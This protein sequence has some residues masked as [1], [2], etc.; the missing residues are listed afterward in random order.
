MALK[1]SL[2]STSTIRVIDLV[3]E[4]EIVGLVDGANSVF[5][6]EISSG[7]REGVTIEERVGLPSQVP[8]EGFPELETEVAVGTQIKF[9]SPYIGVVIDT[10]VDAL[11]IKVRVPA[12]FFINEAGVTK[13]TTLVVYADRRIVGEDWE[14]VFT[15]FIDG[16]SSGNY[17][18]S[19][20]MAKPAGSTG[21]WEFRISRGTK[22]SKDIKLQNDLYISTY[23]LLTEVKLEYPD[24]AVYG[25]TVDTG[26]FGTRIPTRSFEVKGRIIQVPANY[27]PE[28]RDQNN[29]FLWSEE[30]D[31][32]AWTKQ[33][34]AITA[35]AVIAPDGILSADTF[36]EDSST[37]SHRVLQAYSAH[38]DAT[39]YVFS[40]E[41][42]ASTRSWVRIQAGSTRYP[43]SSYVFFNSTDGSIGN[44]GAGIVDSSHYGVEMTAEGFYRFWVA[45]TTT[46][47][48][49]DGWS[50]FLET[51]N[52]VFSYTGDGSSGLHFWGAQI[53][54]IETIGEYR[55]TTD[56]VV[57]FTGVGRSYWGI[58]DGTFKQAWTDNPAWVMYDILTHPRYGLGGDIS[59]AQVDKWGLD[60]IGRYCDELI[61]D[62]EDGTEPRF[63]FNGVISTAKEAYNLVNMFASVFRGMAFWSSNQVAFSQ[64]SPQDY[65]KIIT[66]A[67]VIKGNIDYPDTSMKA[68]FS[69]AAVSWNDP[70]RK[71]RINVEVVED[72][73]LIDRFG[74]KPAQVVAMY[75]TSRGQANRMGLWLLRSPDLVATWRASID[76]ADLGLGEIV[77]VADPAYAGTR[78]GGRLLTGSTV[79]SLVIDSSVD[80]LVSSVYTISVVLPDGSVETVS[81]TNSPGVTSVITVSPDLSQLP[82]DAAMWAISASEA[83]LRLFRVMTVTEIDPMVY[84]VSAVLHDALLTTEIEQDVTL[85]RETFS[86]LPT[87]SLGIPIDP[88]FTQSVIAEGSILRT[89]ITLSWTAPDDGRVIEY[90]VSKRLEEESVFNREGTTSDNFFDLIDIADG[91]ITLRVRSKDALGRASDWAEIFGL[92]NIHSADLSAIT[93]FR[94]DVTDLMVNLGWSVIPDLLLSHYELRYS[95]DI[96]TPEWGSAQVLVERISKSSTETTTPAIAGSYLLRAIGIYGQTSP[97]VYTVLGDDRINPKNVVSTLTQDPDWLGTKTNLFVTDADELRLGGSSFM[98]DWNTL[99]EVIS[100]TMGLGSGVSLSG[101]YHFTLPIDLTEVYVSQVLIQVEAHTINLNNFIGTWIA[102]SSVPNLAGVTDEETS[103]TAQL[104]TTDDDPFAAPVWSSWGNHVMGDHRARGLDFRLILATTNPIFTPVITAAAAVI[105][106]PDRII[107][108]EDITCPAAGL[109]VS[110]SPSFKAKPS[111]VVT[112][113]D[114]ATGDYY[115]VTLQSTTG[116]TLRFFNN[117][118]V[119]I[120]RTFDYVARGFGRV[121]T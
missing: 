104:R 85:T 44:V 59:V 74:W 46:A 21:A 6:D 112:P 66:P 62:G 47:A 30:F 27:Y 102:L 37:G 105:D 22:D 111:L 109:A 89:V 51:G 26:I 41:I 50:V 110:Y 36:I 42:K 25:L 45:A 19:Y 84:E 88:V 65:T 70:S 9:K 67:N 43:A 75:C 108:L 97:V 5:F 57:A 87:G 35:N 8:M 69:V 100:L 96:T 55:K 103:V 92:V 106:M 116:F 1:D 12:L 73:S 7:D 56:T 90:E 82:I 39:K 31:N 119:G 64:D 4:G 121:L 33:G 3:S 23:T 60:V 71:Y 77:A 118:D 40:I 91:E 18:R 2:R 52:G 80:I 14:Q 98:E 61:P 29:F 81:V 34:G 38:L 113:Q 17:E 93:S 20:R 16:K 78:F 28:G 54:A 115:T 24:S 83:S 58:W 68:K 32:A 15:D 53:D 107:G 86:T 72:A 101:I 49:N 117:G 79:S 99:A 114:M 10:P 94:L 76:H 48:G 11:R 13:P 95:A 120:Q 63:T